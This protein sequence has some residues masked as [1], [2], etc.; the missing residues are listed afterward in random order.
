MLKATVVLLA[1]FVVFPIALFFALRRLARQWLRRHPRADVAR[2]VITPT[3]YA[4]SGCLTLVL[5]VGIAARQLEPNGP[6]GQ[7]LNRPSGLLAGTV[8]VLLGFSIAGAT[9][10][11][12]GYPTT[13]RR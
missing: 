2:A 3:G 10:D 1:I 5:L 9:L 13:R 12:L 6:L 11:K 4:L 8:V 7:F